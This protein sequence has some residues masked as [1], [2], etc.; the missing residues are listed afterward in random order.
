MRTP[1]LFYLHVRT[2]GVPSSVVRTRI[3]L[4]KNDA[5]AVY[6]LRTYAA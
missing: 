5:N 6:S 2:A 1:S 4:S 3:L